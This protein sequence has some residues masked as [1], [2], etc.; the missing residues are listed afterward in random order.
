MVSSRL[1]SENSPM[2]FRTALRTICCFLGLCVTPGV[3]P[4]A[5]SE[6]DRL[7]IEPQGTVL[8]GRG[9][10]AQL[11]ATGYDSHGAV[12]DLTHEARWTSSDPNIVI[13]HSNG[14]IEP[15]GDGLAEVSV[16]LRI[17]RGTD[18]D[19]GPQRRDVSSHSIR[20]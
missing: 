11:I 1:A 2:V 20:G 15:R 9:A 7:T 16:P 8:D 18:V 12:R 4:A 19:P 10:S 13:V 5:E 6:P 17:E 14:R 3:A